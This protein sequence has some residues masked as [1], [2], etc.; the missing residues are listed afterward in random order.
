MEANNSDLRH[1][2]LTNELGNRMLDMI[3]PV[4]DRSKVFLFLFQAFGIVLQKE[5]DFIWGDFVDQAFPQ[6]ATWGMDYWEEE[7]GIIPDPSWTLEQRRS[8][9]LAA[10]MNKGS[11]TPRKI[12]DRVGAVLGSPVIVREN[13]APNT[14]EVVTEEYISDLSEAVKILNKI[15]PAH[16]IYTFGTE[17]KVDSL[18]ACNYNFTVSEKET[19]NVTVQNETII[20][21]ATDESGNVL[22]DEKGNLLIY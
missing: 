15:V 5:L 3:A 19:F 6:T 17:V 20:I 13:V 1:E 10:I 21:L 4:Y 8:N 11:M 22:T 2:I 18:A 12:A 16:L 7:Y 14:I 9:F